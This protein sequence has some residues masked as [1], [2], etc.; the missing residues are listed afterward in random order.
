M[1]R[2]A[3]LWMLSLQQALNTISRYL[4]L[5]TMPTRKKIIEVVKVLIITIL[6]G[7]K[8]VTIHLDS[9]NGEKAL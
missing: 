7:G 3:W 8:Q 1:E 4:N 9:F 6:Y 5:G 2:H